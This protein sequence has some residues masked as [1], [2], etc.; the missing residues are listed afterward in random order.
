MIIYNVTLNV[1]DDIH[2]EWLEWMRNEHI[3]AIMQTGLF[4]KYKIFKIISETEETTGFTYAIQYS[5]KDVK[6]FLTYSDLHAPRLQ[7][8]SHDKYGQRVLAFRTLL[9]E[10]E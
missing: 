7:K 10:V 2:T 8:Q 1:E 5:L 4:L 9:E 3:P 6:D